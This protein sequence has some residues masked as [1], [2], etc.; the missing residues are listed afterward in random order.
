MARKWGLLAVQE[1]SDA[2]SEVSA[3]VFAQDQHEARQ[4]QGLD[5]DW[6]M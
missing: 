5:N 6:S 2:V 1:F 3:G 4:V